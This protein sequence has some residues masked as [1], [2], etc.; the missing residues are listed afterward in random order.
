MDILSLVP[1]SVV[2]YLLTVGLG[3]LL[4]K[5]PA[6]LGS[7]FGRALDVALDKASPEVDELILAAVKVA[8]KAIP[9]SGAGEDK[10]ALVARMI[11]GA[12]PQLKLDPDQ[13]DDVIEKAVSAMED[14]AEKRMPP[15]PPADPQK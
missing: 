3:V 1:Q 4:A 5:L 13:L 10:Y 14:E 7:A 15:A 2:T 9:H 6:L 8:E 11:A 12:L